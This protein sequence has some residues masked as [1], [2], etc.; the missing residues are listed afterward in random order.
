MDARAW[1]ATVH[2]V[3]KSWPRLS[4][5]TFLSF[6]FLLR[7]R[8]SLFPGCTHYGIVLKYADEIRSSV[9]SLLGDIHHRRSSVVRRIKWDKT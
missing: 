2:G 4:D 7:V 6:S 8:P 5:Y 3:A 1:D 9:I